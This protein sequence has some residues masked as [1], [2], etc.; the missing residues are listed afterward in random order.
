MRE[1]AGQFAV[2][3]W[4]VGLNSGT[5]GRVEID[6]SATAFRRRVALVIGPGFVFEDECDQAYRLSGSPFVRVQLPMSWLL[7]EFRDRSQ[8]VTL[9]EDEESA[10]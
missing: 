6:M 9:T 1:S 7:D 2:Y 5:T 10:C 8:E 4:L 3:V